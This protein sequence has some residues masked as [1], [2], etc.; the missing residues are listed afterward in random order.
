MHQ[1]LEP[2]APCRCLQRCLRPNFGRLRTVLVQIT[3]KRTGDTQC[4]VQ[5]PHPGDLGVGFGFAGGTGE[6]RWADR[7]SC[8][9]SPRLSP[10]SQGAASDHCLAS[11]EPSPWAAAP[12]SAPAGASSQPENPPR[13]RSP[14]TGRLAPPP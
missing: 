10:L 9:L 13:G 12:T 2:P 5:T 14:K 4:L 7:G 3:S 1:N 6:A 11:Q 8:P